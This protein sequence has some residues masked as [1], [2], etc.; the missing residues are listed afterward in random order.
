MSSSTGNT[1]NIIGSGSGEDGGPYDVSYSTDGSGTITITDTTSGNTATIEI[2]SIPWTELNAAACQAILQCIIDNGT[3]EQISQLNQCLLPGQ[4]ETLTTSGGTLSDG[5]TYTVTGGTS[6]IQSASTPGDTRWNGTLTFT[7]SAPVN[8]VATPTQPGDPDILEPNVWVYQN[9]TSPQNPS[10]TRL[11]SSDGGDIIFIE[12]QIPGAVIADGVIAR[13]SRPSSQAITSS[14]PWGTVISPGGTTFEVRARETDAMNFA[15][16]TLVETDTCD[17]LT[18]IHN[19]LQVLELS[20][21][22]DPAST[23][24]GNLTIEGDDGEEYTLPIKDE[25]CFIEIGPNTPAAGVNAL[26]MIGDLDDDDFFAAELENSNNTDVTIYAIRLTTGLWSNP[27]ANTVTASFAGSTGTVLIGANPGA[28]FDI[29]LSPPLV[30]AA[31]TSVTGNVFTSANGTAQPITASTALSAEQIKHEIRIYS[32]GETEKIIEFNA[33]GKPD[34]ITID[35]LWTPCGPLDDEELAA[36]QAIVDSKPDLWT[37]NIECFANAIV[38]VNQMQQDNGG[39]PIANGAM[40][41]APAADIT[42]DIVIR[43]DEVGAPPTLNYTVDLEIQADGII[44]DSL[45]ADGLGGGFYQFNFGSF[46]FEAGV[47]Y[48]IT[49]S[50]TTPSVNIHDTILSSQ[51][52]PQVQFVTATASGSIPNITIIGTG[53][54]RYTVATLSDGTQIA[55][56]ENLDEIPIDTSWVPCSNN[57]EIRQVNGLEEALEPEICP[58]TGTTE[59]VETLETTAPAVDSPGSLLGFDPPIIISQGVTGQTRETDIKFHGRLPGEFVNAV[60]RVTRLSAG[61]GGLTINENGVVQNSSGATDHQVE[62]ELADGL[63]YRWALYPA[64]AGPS[65]A[66]LFTDNSVTEYAQGPGGIAITLPFNGSWNNGNNGASSGFGFENSNT[67]EFRSNGVAGAGSSFRVSLREVPTLPA[68]ELC[69]RTEALL[70]LIE[71]PTDQILQ[72]ICEG[73]K[74]IGCDLTPDPLNVILTKAATIVPQTSTQNLTV[75]NI[76]AINSGLTIVNDLFASPNYQLDLQ[77]TT[78]SPWI[79][80]DPFNNTLAGPNGSQLFHPNLPVGTSEFTFEMADGGDGSA[81][82]FSAI[83]MATG[84]VISPIIGGSGG[85]SINVPDGG[86]ASGTWRI[87]FFVDPADVR[88]FTTGVGGTNP[89]TATVVAASAISTIRD[90]TNID[91]TLTVFN[92]SA[93]P[94]SGLTVD[95]PALGLPGIALTPDPIPA[96]GSGTATV[97]YSATAAEIASGEVS[98]TASITQE[99]AQTANSVADITPG[100]SPSECN[101]FDWRTRPTTGVAPQDAAGILAGTALDIAAF[102]EAGRTNDLGT[103]WTEPFDTFVDLDLPPTS[104][105]FQMDFANT[106]GNGGDIDAV[107]FDVNTGQALTMQSVQFGVGA[108]GFTTLGSNQG[109]TAIEGSNTTTI[110][111]TLPIGLDPTSVGVVWFDIGGPGAAFSLPTIANIGCN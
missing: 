83:D 43:F 22:D 74:D 62:I 5:T 4:T 79:W 63:S 92:Q 57:L 109:F 106:T 67:L 75:T 13:S 100:T 93:D 105:G 47:V 31:N 53:E 58:P 99:P 69:D 17:A 38:G 96:G 94:I 3:A 46:T 30:I 91:Y 48:T 97:S 18:D 103:T 35:P 88:I 56:D 39:I 82:G 86:T 98:N 65:E 76:G 23:E 81:Y 110:T 64:S 2:N 24:I 36:I 1:Y 20:N 60:I 89:E 90:N 87:P 55:C 108:T 34:E 19:R 25:L 84:R 111:V 107:F 32:D 8:F 6:I 51:P 16:Q 12:D 37:K 28:D 70:D 73:L 66:F 102:T 85:G 29:L 61:G 45:S 72:K 44:V 59:V 104:S 15:A 71:N 27:T 9:G 42:G 50:T 101:Q 68:Q 54:E 33:A 21:V 26:N 49:P 80:T 11:T 52:S 95:D 14:Q 41:W 78:V 40:S 77:G 7:F 10:S